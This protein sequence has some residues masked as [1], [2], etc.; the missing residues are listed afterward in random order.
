[1]T[2]KTWA[3][4]SHLVTLSMSFL[5]LHLRGNVGDG[6]TFI[7]LWTAVSW[8]NTPGPCLHPSLM[9]PQGR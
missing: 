4:L 6:D 9:L 7:A 3:N 2:Q 5:G 1:M 8:R